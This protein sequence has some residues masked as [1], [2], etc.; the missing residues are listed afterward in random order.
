MNYYDAKQFPVLTLDGFG[1]GMMSFDAGGMAF[2]VGELEKREEKLHEPLSAVTWPR[3]I[4]VKTGGGFVDS[5]ASFNVSYGSTG[6]TD[7]GLL[8][9]DS[10]ELPVIQADIGKD[11]VPTFIWGHILKVPLIDQEKLQKVGRSLDQIYDKGLRLAHDKKLDENTYYGFPTHGT[12]GLVNDPRITTVSAAPHTSG[13]TD[14]D[15]N[16][17]TPDEILA[18]INNGLQRTIAASEYD[19]RGMAN[20]VLIPWEQF[21]AITT[22]KVGTTGDKSILTFL[23]ENNI[24]AKAGVDLTILPCRQCKG[25]GT[26]NKDR[27]VFY[28]NDEDM[29]RMN[30]TVPIK[31]L[32]TQVSAEHIAYL[33]PFVTQFS[34]LEWLYLT[35][36]LYVDGI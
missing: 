24:A 30:I 26:G 31:R 11:N 2:L 21:T 9:Q 1:G 8:G 36:A 20:H 3:D 34:A 29:V 14:T 25:A 15:W 23:E 19:N 7:G 18:D 6:G 17:K 12:H 27:M 33:T 32:F 22:R 13:G 10:N 4:P 28:R 35:H 5:V 16:S